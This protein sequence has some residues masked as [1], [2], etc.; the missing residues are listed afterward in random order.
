MR[1]VLVFVLI[2]LFIPSI[3]A[4]GVSPGVTRIDYSDADYR[5]V[6]LTFL[7]PSQG[8]VD[9]EV[10][11]GPLAQYARVDQDEVYI[12][13]SGRARV[14]AIIELP[15]DLELYGVQ[16][17]RFQGRLRPPE[18]AGIIAVTTAIISRVE[19]MFPYPDRYIELEGIT[20]ENVGEGSDA[21]VRWSVVN[22]GNEPVQYS[23]NYWLTESV[24]ELIIQE[25]LSTRTITPGQTQ[26][27]TRIIN[28]RDLPPGQYSFHVKIEFDEQSQSKDRILM[29]GEKTVSVTSF[30]RE[31]T[32]QRINQFNVAVR[33]E[34]NEELKNIRAQLTIGESTARTDTVDLRGMSS[35]NLQGFIDTTGLRIGTYNAKI[36]LTFEDL[37]GE[38]F[39]IEETRQVRI[40]SHETTSAG[41]SNTTII[42]L[43]AL[44]VIFLILLLVLALSL[45]KKK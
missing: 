12:D 24:G 38:R 17:V 4:M 31:L 10:V 14:T 15:D 1:Y 28:T 18:D 6:T 44:L 42:I 5:E 37:E 32:E 45:L 19:I 43:S 11:D 9:V 26:D 16:A 30:N 3:S 2:L 33:N 27:I 36:L 34:W 29:I 21:T 23:T 20:T 40:V 13:S 8:W 35:G 25:S 22:L 41:S 7:N 39:E